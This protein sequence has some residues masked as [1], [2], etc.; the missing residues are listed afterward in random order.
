MINE[1]TERLLWEKIDGTISPDD[2][3]RLRAILS[4]DADARE[5]L[6]DLERL[7]SVLGTVE[8]IE[9]PAAL[10]QRI[11]AGIDFDR[12]TRGRRKTA[13]AWRSWLGWDIRLVAAAAAGLAVGIAGYHLFI[14]GPASES[15]LDTTRLTGTIAI[16]NGTRINAPG[17]SGTIAFRESDDLAVSVIQIASESEKGIDV[18]LEYRGRA[19]HFEAAGPQGGTL[20][21][22]AISGN[23]IL[24]K[25]LEDGKYTATFRREVQGSPLRVRIASEGEVLLDETFMPGGSR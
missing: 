10:R 16:D 23:T 14:S 13:A 18:F 22:I 3:A 5:C 25:E 4:R 17:V 8:E 1:T 24:L 6:G 15:S 9:P 7:S 20:P 2:D 21:D 19:V 11:E 12:Y